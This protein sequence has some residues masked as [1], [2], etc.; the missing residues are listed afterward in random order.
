MKNP[1]MTALAY[2]MVEHMIKLDNKD[3]LALQKEIKEDNP[4]SKMGYVVEDLLSV[5]ISEKLRQ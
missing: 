4:K 1:I 2:V 5:V 3:F